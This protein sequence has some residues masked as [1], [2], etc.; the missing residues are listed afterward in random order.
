MRRAAE[1]VE[2]REE[3]FQEFVE[4]VCRHGSVL[5]VY[6]VGSRVRGDYRASSDF[7]I[8]VVVDTDNILEIAEEISRLRK[9]PVPVDVIVLRRGD[10][11]DPIYKPML[12]H[13]KRL[14]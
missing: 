1:N 5:E 2:R 10:L 12:E 6:L 9:K 7:D 14:C 13:R 8:V 4:S 11:E 3:Y